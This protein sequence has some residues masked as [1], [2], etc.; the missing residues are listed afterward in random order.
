MIPGDASS[1]GFEGCSRFEWWGP[2]KSAARAAYVV[3]DGMITRGDV[4]RSYGERRLVR[5]S[6]PW[7][8]GVTDAL[9]TSRADLELV[10]PMQILQ[11]YSTAA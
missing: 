4:V 8:Y 1:R 11:R 5:Q 9:R 10:R 3:L 7:N 2:T 6:T